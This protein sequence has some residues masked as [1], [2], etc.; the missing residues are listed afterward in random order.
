MKHLAAKSVV[1]DFLMA[2]PNINL[3]LKIP[4]SKKFASIEDELRKNAHKKTLPPRIKSSL[5]KNFRIGLKLS[6]DTWTKDMKILAGHTPCFAPRWQVVDGDEI[7]MFQEPSVVSFYVGF[8]S[9]RK[10]GDQITRGTHTVHASVGQHALV[11]LLEREACQPQELPDTVIEA[12]NMAASLADIG[13]AHSGL[14]QSRFWSSTHT[15]AIP[16]QGGALILVSHFLT[17]SIGGFS[18]RNYSVRTWLSPEQLSTDVQQSMMG[19][20][21]LVKNGWGDKNP[22]FLSN[23]F[24]P[25]DFLYD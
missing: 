17:D 11:R 16:F 4:Q 12:L 15:I 9:M 6:I 19:W 21:K 25:K 3:A 10:G 7:V 13:Q 23:L 2:L 18:K 1:E 8:V 14:T 24:L 20:D 22:E 5:K